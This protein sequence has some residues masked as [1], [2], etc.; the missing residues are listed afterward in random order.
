MEGGEKPQKDF[1]DE[2]SQQNQ[3]GE[4]ASNDFIMLDKNENSPQTKSG[5]EKIITGLVLI[6]CVAAIFLIYYQTKASL[7]GPLSAVFKISQD[8]AN[9]KPAPE[10]KETLAT[11]LALKQKDT[12]NDGL[13]DYDELYIYKTSPYLEDTDGDGFPDKKEID[14]GH[15]PNC[16]GSDDC[17]GGGGTNVNGGLAATGLP[18]NQ[19]EIITQQQALSNQ[20]LSGQAS[21]EAIRAALLQGGIPQETLS[22]ISDEEIVALYHETMSGGA[23]AQTAQVPAGSAA[24]STVVSGNSNQTSLQFQSIDELKKLSGAQ[25]RA[26]L[27]QEGAPADQLSQ[28]SDDQL[29]QIFLEKLN[30]QLS[31]TNTQ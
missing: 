28:I 9:Q 10:A 6:I 17:F 27:L 2:Y 24:T 8:A 3:T 15:D 19:Q 12:D 23:T 31:N 25:I 14:G 5:R 11:I 30:S 29:K 20:L 22:Q 21:A 4:E 13:S 1:W 26:L 7:N 18:A 16:P